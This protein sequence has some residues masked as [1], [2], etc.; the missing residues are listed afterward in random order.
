MNTR[1]MRHVLPLVLILLATVGD[2]RTQPPVVPSSAREEARQKEITYAFVSPNTRENLTLKES[3]RL[4]NSREELDLIYAIRHLSTCLRLKSEV[5]KTIGSWTDGA[6][7]ST[8][9]RIYTDQATARYA[10]ARLG[11]RE[12]QKSVLYFQRNAAGTGRMYILFPRRRR[13]SGL[14]LISRALDRSG[15]PFR[16]LVPGLRRPATVYV[17]D[18]NHEL[19][20]QVGMAARRLGARLVVIKGTGEFIGDD[21]DREKA[22]Q[23]FTGIINQYEDAHPQTKSNCSQPSLDN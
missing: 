17:I 23:I 16:T 11:R 6:E 20:R 8:M 12:R 4:L 2:V 1:L 18:L 14:N 5:V 9:F 10:D 19:E 7:H 13:R 3:L 15:V 21:N 22:R